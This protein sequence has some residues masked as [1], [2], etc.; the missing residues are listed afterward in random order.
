[1]EKEYENSETVFFFILLEAHQKYYLHFL[2]T[3]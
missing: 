2:G 3:T 1:M